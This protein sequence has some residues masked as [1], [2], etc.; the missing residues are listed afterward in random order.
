M[1]SDI[2]ATLDRLSASKSVLGV[3]VLQRSSGSV[4]RCSGSLFSASETSSA[5]ERPEIAQRYADKC[6]SLVKQLEA[7]CEGLEELDSSETAEGN[8]NLQSAEQN[9]RFI[10]L[11]LKRLELLITPG[12]SF[13]SRLPLELSATLQIHVTSSVSFKIQLNR[14]SSWIAQAQAGL[15]PR[16]VQ[17]PVCSSDTDQLQIDKLRFISAC[18]SRNALCPAQDGRRACHSPL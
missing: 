3:I 1:A 6:W 2:E 15:G 7:D 11:R 5:N 16:C 9:V 10:R 4:I 13:L 18:S 12:E 8:A 14:P 17:Y